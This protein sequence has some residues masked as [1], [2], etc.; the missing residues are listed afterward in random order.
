M[1]D[2]FDLKG[3]V[4][5]VTGACGVLGSAIVSYFGRLG[6]KVALLGLE[7]ARERSEKLIAG[8]E[9][10][11][12]E[13][14]FFASDVLREDMLQQS[15][16]EILQRFGTIDVLI[17]AAGGN[18][19]SANVAPE[20]TLFPTKVFLKPMADKGRGS[21]INFCSM[22]S[23]RPLTRVAGYGIA[24][25]GIASWTQWLAGELAAKFGEGL[26]VNAI[27][28]GFILTGQNHSLLVNPDGSLTDRSQSIIA[29]TPIG[30]F[31]KPDEIL[32]AIH[33]LASDASAAVTGTIAV[34]D[35]GFNSFS[36]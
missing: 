21:I 28:P 6:C 4:V 2:L 1:N 16:E 36:I 22:S 26:R 9:G 7:R 8:L 11:P 27:A 34:V 20:Q 5:V 35:G 30:R 24:K 18:L 13:A 31:L 19:S 17:N 33:Y 32:G 23:F 10:T 14:H 12:G 29:H 25:A 3:K 15:R